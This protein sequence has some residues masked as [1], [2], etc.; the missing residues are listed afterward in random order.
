MEYV[1][2]VA[3][4]VIGFTVLYLVLR[5]IVNRWFIN[6]AQ[7]DKIQ[8]EVE[9]MLVELNHATSRNIDLIE[10]RIQDLKEILATAD[11]RIGLLKREEEK[12]EIG[13][14]VYTRIMKNPSVPVINRNTVDDM[15][16]LNVRDRIL[17]LH[18]SG[19]SSSMIANQVG[20]TVGEVE[21]V[22][23]LSEKE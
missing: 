17:N 18:H 7:L 16:A 8:Q 15:P 23:S 4:I 3:L 5:R 9:K 19:F 14:T 13:K 1:V 22:I 10:T 11:K 6:A 2:L 20:K 21:L 12:H